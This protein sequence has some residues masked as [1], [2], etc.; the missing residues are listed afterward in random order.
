MDKNAITGANYGHV[1]PSE[2]RLVKNKPAI[3]KAKRPS[4]V[5]N[6]LET[7][8]GHFSS[9]RDQSWMLT[10]NAGERWASWH[11]P[12]CKSPPAP[13]VTVIR[14]SL[15]RDISPLDYLMA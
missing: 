4:V 5:V 8:V 13:C 15:L 6:N 3:D 14:V 11:L 2:E 12:A 7:L 9:R 10:P 1:R